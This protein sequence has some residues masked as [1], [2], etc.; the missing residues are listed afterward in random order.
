[1]PPARVSLLGNRRRL[2]GRYTLPTKG[3]PVEKT[4]PRASEARSFAA[5]RCGRRRASQPGRR[6]SKLTPLL[7]GITHAP[8]TQRRERTAEYQSTSHSAVL[9]VAARLPLSEVDVS[10]EEAQAILAAL[11]LMAG[12]GECGL[13]SRGSAQPTGA[14]ASL[15]AACRLGEE[16]A[17]A[18]RGDTPPPPSRPCLAGQ[19]GENQPAEP[20]HDWPSERR[21]SCAG[22]CSGAC[23]GL[24]YGLSTFA[25][26]G[27]YDRADRPADRWRE[28]WRVPSRPSPGVRRSRLS[29][30]RRD[31]PRQLEV[32]TSV[33]PNRPSDGPCPG[34]H[35]QRLPIALPSRLHA[36]KTCR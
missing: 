18:N 7:W 32:S 36:Q 12:E 11:V 22:C 16:L 8:Q 6:C 28:P 29:P 26:T 17:I 15:R 19:P 25:T 23:F 10:L 4:I 34:R 9:S 35:Q 5:R 3:A 30:A 33:F 20:P 21:L 2:V 13:R 1:M 24:H 14:G 31:Q 27:G